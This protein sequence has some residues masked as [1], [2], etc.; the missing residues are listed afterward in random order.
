MA[1]NYAD[2]RERDAFNNWSRGIDWCVFKQGRQWR[3]AACFGFPTLFKTKTA[4]YDACT[5]FV[6]ER[7]RRNAE[8]R[9]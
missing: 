8:N 3:A 9:S 5:A 1:C 2:P 6:L 7:S 4:A